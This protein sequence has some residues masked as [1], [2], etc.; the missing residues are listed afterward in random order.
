VIIQDLAVQPG[1]DILYGA[2]QTTGIFPF[3]ASLPE[4]VTIDKITGIVTSKGTL[5][6]EFSPD[7]LASIAFDP[8]TGTLY[9]AD[10][11][12]GALYTVNPTDGIIQ[13]T[14]LTDRDAGACATG[15]GVREDGTIFAS[16]G[17]KI[18][19]I[20]TAGDEVLVGIDPTGESILDLTFLPAEDVVGGELIPIETTSLIL[21]SAQS[22][23]WMIP[24]IVSAL[25]I[26]LFVV[27]KKSENS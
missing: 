23:S 6:V 21:A 4:L 16:V 7:I 3:S 8:N 20:S 26:G 12:I 1:T 5:N 2:T 15:L 14:V 9:A 24:V 11:Q 25:G 13:T 27:S 19:T 17:P 10:C 22:F 18:Y